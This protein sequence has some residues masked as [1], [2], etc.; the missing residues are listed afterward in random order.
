[1]Q[2]TKLN[3]NRNLL[4]FIVTMT[5]YFLA[6]NAIYSE[7]KCTGTACSSIPQNYLNQFT[8]LDGNFRNQYLNVVT[9]SM[10]KSALMSNTGSGLIGAGAINRVQIGAGASV[11]AVKE[12]DITVTSGDITFPK[13]PAGGVGIA[14]YAMGA[15]NLGWL[16]KKGPS[17][18]GDKRSFLHRFNIY[19]HGLAKHYD[20][21]PDSH[22]KTKTT[23]GEI[24]S[25]NYGAMVRFQ[26]IRDFYTKFYMFGFTGLS[27][28]AGFNSQEFHLTLEST[29]KKPP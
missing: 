25:K 11:G 14:P 24:F 7:V 15:V 12:G 16:F 5:A 8:Q 2:K 6:G 13:M 18:D 28:G 3:I 17:E 19:G 20:I 27:I 1:M 10:L 9:D 23:K 22:S 29:E 21:E 4:L 26:I